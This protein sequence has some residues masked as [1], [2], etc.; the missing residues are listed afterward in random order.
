MPLFE[1]P[2]SHRVFDSLCPIYA[3][4]GEKLRKLADGVYHKTLRFSTFRTCVDTG[5]QYR[6]RL[7]IR[8]SWVRVPP[9]SLRLNHENPHFL[10]EIVGFLLDGSLRGFVVVRRLTRLSCTGALQL[11]VQLKSGSVPLTSV[12]PVARCPLLSVAVGCGDGRECRQ[13]ANHVDQSKVAVAVHRQCDGRMPREL[14]GKF[15]MNTAS[16]SLLMNVS[17]SEW[18]SAMPASVT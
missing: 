15:R 3:Q 18:K 4:S 17:R 1:C 10:R 9:P 12:V 7:L 6:N 8:R 13:P 16:D 5:G 2:L 11:F 14:L